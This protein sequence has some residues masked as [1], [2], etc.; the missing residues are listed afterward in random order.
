MTPSTS[1]RIDACRLTVASLALALSAAAFSGAAS[2]NTNAAAAAATCNDLQR[3]RSELVNRRIAAIV[4]REAPS[5]SVQRST[6][7]QGIVSTTV[8]TGFE[9]LL[10]MDFGALLNDLVNQGITTASRRAAS[11]FN[12]NV[13]RILRDARIP[14]VNMSLDGLASSA[15]GRVNGVQRP[16]NANPNA[17]PNGGLTREQILERQRNMLNQMNTGGGA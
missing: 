7:V 13:N 15:Q 3:S 14:N 17:S 11:E 16:S 10:Q 2:A 5:A 9:R 6:D 8:S 12:N 4:P 1:H